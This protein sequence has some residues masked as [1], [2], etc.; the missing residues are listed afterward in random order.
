MLTS[1][2]FRQVPKVL[3]GQKVL[4]GHKVRPGHKAHRD[5]KVREVQP[6]QLGLPAPKVRRAILESG[7]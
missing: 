3:R 1:L 5:L 2:A 7:F 4:R 6:V